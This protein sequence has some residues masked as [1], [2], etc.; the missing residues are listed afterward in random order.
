[1]ILLRFVALYSLFDAMNVIFS[2]ALRGAGDTRFIMTILLF[3]S[4]LVLIIPSWI[5]VVLL[6]KGI[7][8]AW[9][10]ATIYVIALAVLFFTRF[11]KGKWKT[12]RVI[13]TQL[14]EN[15]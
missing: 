3:I 15:F 4:V 14:I 13:E 5:F 1:M 10:I 9:T 7:Y 2:S 11:L 8:V 12:M 6:Q